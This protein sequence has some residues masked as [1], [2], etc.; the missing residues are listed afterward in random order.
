MSKPITRW[1]LVIVLPLLALAY[2]FSGPKDV[3]V[4]AWSY[5]YYSGSQLFDNRLQQD[6]FAA[7]AQG[8][9]NP[10]PHALFAAMVYAD[11][12]DRTIAMVLALLGSLVFLSLMVFYQQILGLDRWT[13]VGVMALSLVSGVVWSCV[14]TSTAD[15]YVQLPVVMALY[16]M[17]RARTPQQVSWLYGSGFLWGISAGI[18][19]SA[20]IYIPGV[21]AVVLYGLL[22]Q[23]F[24]PYQILA[25]IFFA[26]LGIAVSHG[27]WGWQ[28]YERFGNPFFPHFNHWFHSPDYTTEALVDRRFISIDWM[29]Q[30]LLPWRMVLSEPFIYLEIVAPDIK[31]AVFATSLV[32]LAPKLLMRK[33]GIL[34][35]IENELLIFVAI[36]F[37]AWMLSSGNGRYAVTLFLLLG[38][39]IHIT[40]KAFF[41]P[42]TIRRVFMVILFLQ[43]TVF[44]TVKD[45][46]FSSK[47]WGNSWYGVKIKH[48]F[49]DGLVF[50]TTD[51]AMSIFTRYAGKDTAFVAPDATYY[52]DLNPSVKKMIEKYQGK[53]SALLILPAGITEE[54]IFSDE[55]IRLIH[56]LVYER[57]G[58]FA[59]KYDQG[60]KCRIIRA[61]DEYK[62]TDMH[63]MQCSL[64][65]D[66]NERVRYL[67]QVMLPQEYFKN[68]ENRCGD[69]LTPKDGAIKIVGEGAEKFYRGSDIKIHIQGDTVVAQ[70]YWSMK[71][72]PMGSAGSF[73]KLSAEQWREK[74]CLPLVTSG[75]FRQ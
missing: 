55:S 54:N 44:F 26:L 46:R 63:L 69:L 47:S 23:R 33:P 8:Y 74:Y 61:V 4:D 32:L 73:N 43:A 35:V 48:Q 59:L 52:F 67:D 30:L 42:A 71:T 57:V 18:K 5:H 60:K 68:V 72:F 3:T 51:N 25:M 41:S 56:K 70:K 65:I 38:A 9:F 40:L 36:T 20:L 27:W 2:T 50:V 58:R 45:Y 14:G 24:T 34:S 66:V 15:L 53:T 10:L 12:Q 11:W 62:K 39:C 49:E 16:A 22:T 19:L 1:A 28:L 31:P 17:F 13:L 75:R 7:S 37:L 29:K 6:Y 21:A 64:S